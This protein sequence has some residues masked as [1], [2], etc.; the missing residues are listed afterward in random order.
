MTVSTLSPLRRRPESHCVTNKF[1]NVAMLDSS[2][3][4]LLFDQAGVGECNGEDDNSDTNMESFGDDNNDC[5]DEDEGIVDMSKCSQLIDNSSEQLYG[6]GICVLW[7]MQESRR[8]PREDLLDLLIRMEHE[9]DCGGCEGGMNKLMSSLENFRAFVNNEAVTATSTTNLLRS[10]S[11]L[12]L[13]E[14]VGFAYR[15]RRHEVAMAL[16]RIR[17][18][19]FE[20]LPA[21]PIEVAESMSP[22]DEAKLLEEESKKRTLAELWEN[23]RRK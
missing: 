17:G 20:I 15:P 23:R 21:K 4:R 18:M 10:N 19:K 14:T 9:L 7:L 6:C 11:V 2:S 12:E 1:N 8:H 3:S 16:T 5:D 13:W 22:E